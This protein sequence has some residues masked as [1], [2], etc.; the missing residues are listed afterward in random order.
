MHVDAC[1][2]PCLQLQGLLDPVHGLQEGQLGGTQWGNATQHGWTKVECVRKMDAGLSTG[3]KVCMAPG[4]DGTGGTI[5][6]LDLRLSISWQSVSTCT[7]CTSS[8]HIT[9]P[10]FSFKSEHSLQVLHCKHFSM[11]HDKTL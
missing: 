2:V 8:L 10:N 1:M 9:S 3:V 6:V 11:F 5:S 4:G 7:S